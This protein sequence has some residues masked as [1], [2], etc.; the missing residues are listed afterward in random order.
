MNRRRILS[1]VHRA[2][3]RQSKGVNAAAWF[4]GQSLGTGI[5]K[6]WL[7]GEQG[8]LDD[9]APV[10]SFYETSYA[11]AAP[12]G[13]SQFGGLAFTVA[14]HGT[15]GVS[16]LPLGSQ[17][18]DTQQEILQPQILSLPLTQD[19]EVYAN[20]ESERARARFETNAL[21]NDGTCDYFQV[22]R[23]GIYA[24]PWA[25]QRLIRGPCR[26]SGVREAV[27]APWTSG[28][29]PPGTLL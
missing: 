12:N 11:R 29:S 15:L 3:A 18:G 13:T 14:G 5:A 9:G 20:L 2:I 17:A 25:P 10:D 4:A 19:V 8:D 27:P 16:L 28:V 26:R 7:L 24:M 6:V 21:E 23:V 1:G 22:R